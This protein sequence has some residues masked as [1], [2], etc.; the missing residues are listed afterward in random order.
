MARNGRMKASPPAKNLAFFWK[1]PVK[2]KRNDPNFSLGKIKSAA[3]KEKEIEEL[4][5]QLEQ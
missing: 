2:E 5:K 1:N 4:W 3:K